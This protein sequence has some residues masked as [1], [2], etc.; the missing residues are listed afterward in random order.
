[1]DKELLSIGRLVGRRYMGHVYDSVTTRGRQ[2][3]DF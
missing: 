1:M 3:R 2:V